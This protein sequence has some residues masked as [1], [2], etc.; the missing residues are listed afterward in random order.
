MWGC[1]LLS[2]SLL[3]YALSLFLI[4][5]FFMLT[6]VSAANPG[7]ITAA[8]VLGL[9]NWVLAA[10]AIGL[11]IA[12]P[13][14]P[15]HYGY[16]IAAAVAVAVHAV[17]LLAVINRGEVTAEFM[18]SD[19]GGV[20]ADKWGQ[21][22]TKLDFLTLYLACLVYPGEFAGVR[23]DLVLSILTGVAEMVRLVFL[24]MAL[25]CLARAAGDDELSHRCTRAA[26]VVSI[27]PGLLAIGMLGFVALLVETNAR[28][29]T[30]G[31]V[32]MSV[33]V[34][35]MY[36]IIAGLIVPALVAAKDTAFACE[37]PFQS[38]RADLAP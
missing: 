11:C 17:F 12:G 24:M 30:A 16:S 37:F 21:L 23:S 25:S 13:K 10:V 2:F 38:K 33:I 35:G 36:A 34:M 29:S 31:A 1:K 14:S 6:A 8:G 18:K 9:C 26:G 15:G 3:F 32:M 4:V 22:P 7:L 5:V 27:G 28:F 19:T 20:I